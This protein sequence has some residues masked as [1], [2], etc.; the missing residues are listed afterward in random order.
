[1]EERGGVR[2]CSASL[3]VKVPPSAVHGEEVLSFKEGR[4]ENSPR[5]KFRSLNPCTLAADVWRR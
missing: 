1:M 2:R 4:G 3:K 5:E